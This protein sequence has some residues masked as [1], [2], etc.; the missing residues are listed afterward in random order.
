[1][2]AKAYLKQVFKLDTMITNKLLEK[3]RWKAIALN[4]TARYEGE[5]VQT[6]GNPQKMSDA[7]ARYMDIEQEINA[8]IDSLIDRRRD[9][10]RLIENLPVAEYDV[11]HKRYIQGMTFDEIGAAVD[12]SKSWAT[13]VHGRA[14][15]SVQGLLDEREN[16]E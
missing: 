8:D 12:K 9:I 5:R 1:M 16:K 13:S 2:D 14:L 15:H 3:E 4:T 6:S 7:I 11:L 10:S